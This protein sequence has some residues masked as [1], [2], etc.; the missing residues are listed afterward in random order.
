MRHLRIPVLI[1]T[2]G[3]LVTACGTATEPS[4]SAGM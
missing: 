4:A 2:M 3:L 1:V